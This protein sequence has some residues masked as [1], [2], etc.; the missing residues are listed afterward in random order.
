[1]F[2]IQYDTPTATRVDVHIAAKDS[3]GLDSEASWEIRG[4]YST[5]GRTLP[6]RFALNRVG[7]NL[8]QGT[9]VDPCFWGPAAPFLYRLHASTDAA[10][11]SLQQP[12]FEFGIRNLQV[13]A[14][15]LWLDGKRWVL[16]GAAAITPCGQML[17]AY[18]DELLCPIVSDWDEPFIQEASRQ[19][20]PVVWQPDPSSWRESLRA[21]P[22]LAAVTAILIPADATTTRQE[23]RQLAPNRLILADVDPVNSA[24]RIAH[25]AYDWCDAIC[26][27][28]NQANIIESI[29]ATPNHGPV[30][31]W[32]SREE[33]D[34]TNGPSDAAAVHR[35]RRLCETLQATL[36]PRFHVSGY[37]IR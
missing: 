19:G 11:I 34:T 17:Q 20:I 6:T 16:R 22:A 5:K 33:P 26:V 10:P 9:I 30:I 14:G 32:N 27:H 21:Y 7:A 3:V 23:L 4:P 25:A 31:A 12:K 13:N 28:A 37:L 29:L 35:D 1:M 15:Q 2:S 24:S 8:W 36:A 18:Q